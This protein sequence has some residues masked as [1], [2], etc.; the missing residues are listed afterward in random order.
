[1]HIALYIV[2]ARVENVFRSVNVAMELWTVTIIV[3]NTIVVSVY[4]LYYICSII[5]VYR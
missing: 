2:V 5:S 4:R 1:M 3:T